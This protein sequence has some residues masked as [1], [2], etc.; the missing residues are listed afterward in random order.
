MTYAEAEALLFDLPRFAEQGAAAMKPG[1]ERMHAL[2][3]AMGGPHTRFRSVHVAGTNG[4]GSTASMVAAIATAAGLRTGL[5]TS[6]HLHDL[7]ERLRL[8]GLP[9]PHGWIADAVA[10]HR[11]DFEAAR[12][13]F[14]EATVALSLLYFAEQAVDLAVVEVGLG[15]RLDATNVLRP[16]IALV[17]SIGLDHADLLGDTV[18][19]VAR[20]KAGIAKPGVPLLTSAE[21]AGILGALREV[22]EARGAVFRSVWDEV[23][24]RALDD[25][26]GGLVLDLTTPV[27]TYERL[28]IGLPGQHQAGN[29]A[30]AVR[31]AEAVVGAAASDAAPVRAGLAGV[32]K[33][34]GLAAR[35]EVIQHAPLVLADVAHNADGLRAA[36]AWARG[37]ASGTLYV[38]FGTMA[39]KDLAAMTDEL[40]RSGAVALPVDLPTPRAVPQDA[41]RRALADAGVPVRA[42]GTVADALAWYRRRAAPGDGLLAV[43]SHLVAADLRRASVS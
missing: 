20:E 2:L 5:H 42:V 24:I 22:A 9:A 1:L 28:E 21:G 4:K 10:R 43:G 19:A 36:L 38:L 6:P 27:R 3:G 13:S 34:S 16:E 29:A 32:R 12:P 39:D 31:A 17:T 11:A 37:L 33:L 14:F 40:R 18:E 25:P 23:E 35:C 7:A 26:A 8:D 30:L 41:L 15:G